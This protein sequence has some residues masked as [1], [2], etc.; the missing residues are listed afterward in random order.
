MQVRHLILS[1]HL[2]DAVLSLGGL[3]ATEG[4]TCAVMTCFSGAPDPVQRTPWD[5]LT[6]FR[7]SAEAMRAR[8]KEN[9]TA[10][11]ILLVPESQIINL[12]LLDW[13][14]RDPFASRTDII[15]TIVAEVLAYTGSL[16][17]PVSVYAPG[18]RKHPDHELVGEA[19]R[20]LQRRDTSE[21][22]FFFY[23]DLPYAVGLDEDALVKTIFGG[24]TYVER[25]RIALTED[26]LHK[27]IE[28]IRAYESQM[29][30]L[31]G[32]EK[33]LKDIEEYA[34]A[35]NAYRETVYRIKRTTT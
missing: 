34:K 11:S 10:L 24:D 31:G 27:K 22:E 35:G 19:L 28:A 33:L 3:L 8:I 30:G 18:L 4:S 29:A 32:E 17:G 25:E 21:N 9:R 23:A 6:G 1:P 2:D 13:Q 20:E 14:Y 26:A 5:A 12:P 16:E 7:D 15:E